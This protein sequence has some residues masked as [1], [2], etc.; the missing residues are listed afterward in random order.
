MITNDRLVAVTGFKIAIFIGFLSIID[1][2]SDRRSNLTSLNKFSAQKTYMGEIF[3]LVPLLVIALEGGGD[4]RT[5][6][7]TR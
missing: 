7:G 5:Q 6:T 3:R 2:L 4:T 1:F